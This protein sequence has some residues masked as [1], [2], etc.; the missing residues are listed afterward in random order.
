MKNA[1]KKG[2]AVSVTTTTTTPATTVFQNFTDGRQGRN[3]NFV[4]DDELSEIGKNKLPN[5]INN[6][7][8]DCVPKNDFLEYFIEQ[9]E[10]EEEAERELEQARLELELARRNK[11]T[12]KL[13]K[14]QM[15]AVLVDFYEQKE[16]V[17]LL[18]HMK[19]NEC[20]LNKNAI[21]EHWKNNRLKQMKDKGV[22][23]S[24]AMDLYRKW[25]EEQRKKQCEVNRKN[26]KHHKNIPANLS[27]FMYNM[28]RQL[29]LCGQG[30]N[31][32]VAK[33]YFVRP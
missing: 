7:H 31:K 14:N 2:E 29:A 5:T 23:L 13:D 3:S 15:E 11:Q 18:V 28:I 19:E 12:K 4:T 9:V 21:Y 10:A 6:N 20:F 32:R 16:R 25:Q 1:A 8:L 27:L 22:Q 17:T 30:I 24:E 26:A 33:K